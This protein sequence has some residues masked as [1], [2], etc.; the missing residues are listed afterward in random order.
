MNYNKRHSFFFCIFLF[1]N[2]LLASLLAQD[3][4]SDR[5]LNPPDEARPRAY[6]WWLNSQVTREGITHDLEEMRAKGYGGAIIF[7]AGNS[8]NNMVVKPPHGPLFGSKEW[9]ELF[10]HTLKEGE[11]L[12][13]ELSAN[14]Q[15]GWNLGGPMVKEHDALRRIFWADTVVDGGKPLA[16]DLPQ[17]DAKD[18]VPVSVQAYP[19][20]NQTA[21]HFRITTIDASTGIY[22]PEGVK[23]FD[24]N[25]DTYWEC[26]APDADNPAYLQFELDNPEKLQ[27]FTITPVKGF[28]PKEAELMTSDGVWAPWSVKK[29][30]FQGNGQPTV[31]TVKERSF[32]IIRLVFYSA[33]N[34]KIRIASVDCNQNKDY[35]FGLFCWEY[36]SLKRQF[37]TRGGAE[38]L[39]LLRQEYPEDV[40]VI[41]GKS[42]QM[43]DLS[44]NVGA[45]GKLRWNVPAG[46][47]RI[48]NY[49]HG[50]HGSHVSSC[51]DGWD[52]L[53][54]DHLS[55]SAFLNYMS[56]VMDPVLDAAKPYLG[57]SLKYLYTDSWEMGTPNWTRDFAEQFRKRRGY[58]PVPFLGVL[59]G[60]IIDSRDVSD[61]F[62]FDLRK[63]V[64]DL[65][66]ER[67][68]AVFAD[69]A[70]K[71]GM[72]I[73]PESGGPHGAPIDALKNLGIGAFPQGEFWA[74][75]NTHRVTDDQRLFVKQFASAAHIYGKQWVAAEG[76]TS[77]GPHW[78]RSPRELRCVFN[79]VYL[80]GLN[81]LVWHTFTSSPKEFGVPGNE[82]FA[83]T[84][85]NPNVTWWPLAKPFIDYLS[86]CDYMLSRGLFVADVC[87]YVGDDVP[88][89]T[90]R[91]VIIDGLGEGFDYDYCN[92]DVILT[93]MDVK[94]GRIVLPDGMNY[95]LLVLPEDTRAISLSVLRKIEQMV[96]SGAVVVGA[97]PETSVGLSDYANS[98][99]EVKAIAAKV[100]GNVDGK[101][102]FEHAYGKG[103]VVY[104]KPLKD[105]LST[106]GYGP[107]FAFRGEREDA[108]VGYI[109]RAAGDTD[110][111]FVA[112]RLARNGVYDTKYKYYTSLPDRYDKVNCR[113]RVTGKIPEIFDPVTGKTTQPCYFK[114]DSGYT[115]V[116]VQF[117]PDGSFFVVFRKPLPEGVTGELFPEGI[118]KPN[119]MRVIDVTGAWDLSFTPGWGAP[120]KVVFPRLISW[121]DT[122][123]DGIKYYSGIATYRKTI[124]VD[125]KLRKGT[126]VYLNLGN[127]L[128][129]AE[130]KVNGINCG[131]AWIAP[132]K[133]D[134]SNAVKPG[135]N[136]LEIRVANLWPNRIIGD[137]NLPA[138]QRYTKTNVVKFKKTD[139]LRPSGLLGPVTITTSEMGGKKMGKGRDKEIERLSD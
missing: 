27:T 116:P 118:I 90:R 67:H 94:N 112:N 13:L 56:Q 3:V 78:E 92:S 26:Q 125:F 17:S 86:R 114:V 129:L 50:L 64:A 132:F 126:E 117:T 137:L 32:K 68:Y 25:P 41:S 124:H 29:F 88:N 134:I 49:V 70:R 57:K 40:S 122:S 52:G 96:A 12:G 24:N 21:K 108:K 1:S 43:I 53:S 130:V 35:T 16:C 6:W 81:R 79:D 98:E 106:M 128:E 100:W 77:I 127:V 120:E 75:A 69:Y 97:R 110:I 131:T 38:P 133:V 63:T 30:T 111:Y 61:R 80:E 44:A 123:L 48:V 14:I 113:F 84:H 5:F 20:L 85:L 93:R 107:D 71:R 76:P 74:R 46:R 19:L 47:W 136:T 138:D 59:T 73:H 23:A 8:S 15:S 34:Q 4:L 119:P 33:Y 51:S 36:K 83:G 45:D 72:D 55:D 11:R 135:E 102:V 42:S 2:F 9:T 115:T 60:E 7:D 87:F 99:K 104:G 121:P 65:I 39:Y 10:V 103:K 22:S 28:E 101:T 82:Y 95:K 37:G 54:L 31:V 109:H 58:D 18:P 62:L 66:A 91:R 105:I 89:F 139:A